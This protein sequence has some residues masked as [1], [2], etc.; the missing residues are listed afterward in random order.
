LITVPTVPLF[1]M[2]QCGT[3]ETGRDTFT[4]PSLRT[5]RIQ[6]TSGENA[7]KPLTGLRVQRSALKST[8]KMED[9]VRV[10]G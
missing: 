1:G 9:S 5:K 3:P 8:M 7:K 10:H 6:N 2:S 4:N